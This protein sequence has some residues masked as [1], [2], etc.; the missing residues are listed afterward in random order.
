MGTTLTGTTPQDTYDSLI[1]VT[2]NGPIGA[3]AKYLSDGLGNDSVLALSTAGVGVG[4]TTPQGV[5]EA[6]GL[7]YFTRSS[8]SLLINP[9]YGGTDI[10]AQIQAATTMGLS[11][12]TD[13]DNDRLF[14][15][16][17]GLV[18]IGTSLPAYLLS[19]AGDAGLQGNE[20]YLYF[21]SDYSIGSNARARMRAVGAGGGSGYGGDLRI[22]TR[23]QNNSWNADVVTI[24]NTGN[25]G[26]GT[27]TPQAKLDAT[28]AGKATIAAL[29]T[30]AFAAGVG[31]SIDL[32]GTYR[33]AGD[34]QAFTR[35]AAEK[36]NATDGNFGYDLGFYVTTNGGSTQGTKVATMTSTG[37]V[38]LA[39]GQ[40]KFPATQVPSS[41]ANT[42]DDYE[43]GIWTLGLSFGGGTTGIDYSANSG[44]YTK[45]GRQV[46][47]NGYIALSSKGSSAGSVAITGLPFPIPSTSPYYA[48]PSLWLNNVSFANQFIGYTQ[49]STSQIRLNELTEA[50]VFSDLTDG[51]FANNSEIMVSMTYFV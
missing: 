25:V 33:S 3:T 42:L 14:I 29:D 2:D 13:G 39:Q 36:S 8:K 37:V 22:D 10:N 50:G 30:T 20:N 41:D 44:T 35:I 43:E 27:S 46:T 11:L 17:T 4:I 49:L 47:V 15:T 21:H 51:N 32:G 24:A 45:I 34:F 19:S 1:K 7:S 40:I 18:G 5:F 6:V 9:N 26:I 23:A 38:D 12:A 28:K 16:S 31:G 48:P